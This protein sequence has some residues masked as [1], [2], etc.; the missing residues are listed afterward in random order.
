LTEQPAEPAAPFV[1]SP[2]VPVITEA[3]AFAIAV[4]PV[5][6]VASVTVILLAAPLVDDPVAQVNCKTITIIVGIKSSCKCRL[7]NITSCANIIGLTRTINILG[8]LG[9]EDGNEDGDDGDDDDELDQSEAFVIQLL[10]SL[11]HFC[12]F[13]SLL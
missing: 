3:I 6:G 11:F 8:V 7:L 1:P 5:V 12:F 2:A 4:A 10:K 13:L 9:S